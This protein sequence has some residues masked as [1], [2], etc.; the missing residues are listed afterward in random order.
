VRAKLVHAA[1]KPTG[2]RIRWAL[3]ELPINRQLKT[4]APEQISAQNYWLSTAE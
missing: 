1:K 4:N 2:Y 3:G